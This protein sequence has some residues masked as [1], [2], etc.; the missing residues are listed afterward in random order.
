MNVKKGSTCRESCTEKVKRTKKEAN[1]REKRGN[2]FFLDVIGD[3]TRTESDKP[4]HDGPFVSM[5]SL[6]CL[7]HQ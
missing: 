5:F 4:D 3:P 2:L 7:V 6:V 1:I